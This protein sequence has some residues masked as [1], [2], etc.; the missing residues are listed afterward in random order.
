MK[1]LLSG[2]GWTQ[3]HVA[4]GAPDEPYVAIYEVT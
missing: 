3:I 2:T 4:V 1:K